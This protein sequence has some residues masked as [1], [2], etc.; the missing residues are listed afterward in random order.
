MWRRIQS[1]SRLSA[2]E[3]ASSGT[4]VFRV[5]DERLSR[6]RLER[7][8]TEQRQQRRNEEPVR[9]AERPRALDGLPDDVDVGVV[10]QRHEQRPE[11]RML[12][13]TER[14]CRLFARAGD[15]LARVAD[16]PQERDLR[17]VDVFGSAAVGQR[18]CGGHRDARL[19]II[20]VPAEEHRG[21]FVRER[22]RGHGAPPLER[23]RPRPGPCAR[24]S[25]SSGSRSATRMRPLRAARVA[26]TRGDSC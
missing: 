5:S 24:S 16:D 25:G 7:A 19:G 22:R 14:R 23:Q 10:E 2:S 13:A 15:G 18:D 6:L 1:C 26:R 9:G 17:G 3:Y 20:E 11:A 4:I 8:V 21:I 12:D